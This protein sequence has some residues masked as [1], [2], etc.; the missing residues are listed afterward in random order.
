MGNDWRYG[1]LAVEPGS[2]RLVRDLRAHQIELEMQN[3][4]LREAQRIIE[5][6]RIR[7]C[8]L[9]D[10]APVGYCTLD[11]RGRIQEINLT[12]AA[13]LRMS[14]ERLVDMPLSS[15][16]CDGDA[17]AFRGHLQRCGLG[18][19]R[20]STEVR[21]AVEGRGTLVVQL[22]S[23][24]LREVGGRVEGYRTAMVDVTT[25]TQF[26]DRLRFLADLG[27]RLAWSLDF[28]KIVAAIAELAVPFVADA[29]FVDLLDGNGR[30][31]RIEAVFADP[32]KQADLGE[33]ARLLAPEL[34]DATPQASV[35]TTGEAVLREEI[36]L[37]ANDGAPVDPDL[38]R[39]LRRVGAK[40]LMVVPLRSGS[41]LLGA[42]TFASC[43]SG[44]RYSADDLVFA[45]EIARRASTAMEN[46]RLHEQARRAVQARED[47]LA[48]VSHDLRNP[49]S[50]IL[51][52]ATL[53]QHAWPST[54]P[55]RRTIEAIRRSALRMDRLISDLLDWSAIEAGK[56]SIETSPQSVDG[57]VRDALEALETPAAQK[58]IRL[59]S[60]GVGDLAVLCDRER[61]L[62]VFSNLIGNAIKFTPEGGAVTVRVE[63]RGE[64]VWFFVTDTGPGIP[65]D[66]V[67]KLFDRFWQAK[68]T[69]R[70]GTGLGLTIAKGIVEAQ[71]GRIGV[72][73]RVGAGSTFFFTLPRA[74]EAAGSV[75][76][77]QREL[78]ERRDAPRASL[79]RRAV[80]VVDDDADTRAAMGAALRLHGYEVSF[81]TDGDEALVYLRRE[82]APAAVLLD[83]SM[84]SKDGWA[85]LV[86]RA[87][88]ESLRPIPVI[89]TS[90]QR[91]VAERL[92]EA[93]A[94]YVPKPVRVESLVDAIERLSAAA[95]VKCAGEW[96]SK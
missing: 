23:Q 35:L 3:R 51:V 19:G 20:V 1:E 33:H 17:H 58:R 87:R 32:K 6:S 83:L 14:R 60:V 55:A 5:S 57:V 31:E 52:S 11:S 91:D 92:A 67:P 77:S 44:R 69:A 15:F 82:P 21:L 80:L 34:D 70:L 85:F 48:V 4:E 64:D 12:G 46:A 22:V 63:P 78:A 40:S 65:A 13:L 9:Y 59:S 96:P 86:E 66:Q 38:A 79:P 76:D 71:D 8:D 49:L 84:P 26:E 37:V 53:A 94:R 68:K 7:Y 18:N 95:P 41:G 47:L 72:E 43:E 16:I 89:V 2:A 29:C 42:L 73:S 36:A 24:P 62:Q 28:R 90:A 75:P 45:Q 81:A 54:D 93:D 10:F 74:P 25:L 30:T 56:L 27:D 61:M 39:F 88:D 50:V